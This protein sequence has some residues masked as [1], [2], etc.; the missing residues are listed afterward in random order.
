MALITS[1]PCGCPSEENDKLALLL[2]AAHTP[3]DA[4]NL[5]RALKSQQHGQ[6]DVRLPPENE[7][8]VPSVHESTQGTAALHN[9]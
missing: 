8:E 5:A 7:R 2:R 9:T 4:V 1:L 6:P 3:D